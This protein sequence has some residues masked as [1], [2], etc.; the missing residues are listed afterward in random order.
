MSSKRS[1]SFNSNCCLET[2]ISTI[3]TSNA[4]LS[5]LLLLSTNGD[6][7]TSI[8]PCLGTLLSVALSGKESCLLK[9]V[10]CTS[11]RANR[12]IRT[13]AQAKTMP[14]GRFM[15]AHELQAAGE[16]TIKNRSHSK[17]GVQEK[18]TNC[19]SSIK[20]K[21]LFTYEGKSA[22]SSS[23]TSDQSMD[24]HFQAKHLVRKDLFVTLCRKNFRLP[25]A[26]PCPCATTEK[27]EKKYE[28]ISEKTLSTA[29]SSLSSSHIVAQ[30]RSQ[31]FC[32]KIN[33]RMASSHLRKNCKILKKK[34]YAASIRKLV[35]TSTIVGPTSIPVEIL[36]PSLCCWER[37]KRTSAAASALSI[38][39]ANCNA[40]A[41]PTHIFPALSNACTT[42]AGYQRD[43]ASPCKFSSQDS[44]HY[45]ATLNS[46]PLICNEILG[47]GESSSSK[48]FSIENIPPQFI[49]IGT[50]YINRLGVSNMSGEKSPTNC[51]QI[52]N[53]SLAINSSRTAPP[54]SVPK[55][56]SWRSP[57][58]PLRSY[59]EYCSVKISCNNA[60]RNEEGQKNLMLTKNEYQP[61]PEKNVSCLVDTNFTKI[62]KE[63]KIQRNSQVSKTTTKSSFPISVE[64]I[65]S[66]NLCDHFITSISQKKMDH[67]CSTINQETNLALSQCFFRSQEFHGEIS[68]RTSYITRPST[69]FQLQDHYQMRVLRSLES[70][71]AL[72]KQ[73]QES[74][75][76]SQKSATC[77]KGQCWR[78]F[79]ALMIVLSVST[80]GFACP[81]ACV[82][83]WKVGHKKGGKE[84]VECVNKGL[85]SLP[86][87]LNPETQVLDFTGN[88]LVIL[89]REKFKI[90][91]L[92]NLQRIYVSRCKL[93]QLDDA[94]FRGLSNLVELDLSNNE[95][96]MVPAA[97][98][99]HT[100]ALMRLLLSH[101][102]I[103]QIRDGAF[104]KLHFLTS[105]EMTG[106]AL[107]VLESRAFQGLDKLEWLKL[108][109]NQLTSVPETM[110]LPKMLHGV[111]L[112]N[113]PWHCDC[114]LQHLRS[115]LVK[116]NVPS[117]I[118]PK[119]S[120][121]QRLESQVIK[122]V[123]PEDFACPPEIRPTSLFLDV[124][125]GKNVSFACHVVAEPTADID[126]RFNGYPLQN[127]S[128]IYD[129]TTSFYIY[130]DREIKEETVSYLRIEMVT[131]AHGGI[132]Q[133]AAENTAGKMISNFTLR[134][135]VPPTVPVKKDFIEDNF[136]YIGLALAGLVLLVFIL[137]CILLSKCCRKKSRHLQNNIDA[138]TSTK[139]EKEKVQSAA[140]ISSM[141]KYIQ[142][143]TPTPKANGISNTGV[144]ISVIEASP[145]R[146]TP[147]GAPHP[148]P[149]IISD[150]SV[151]ER[152]KPKKKVSIM[153]VEEVDPNGVITT[154]KL[155]DIVEEYEDNFSVP[156]D[157]SVQN[158]NDFD[159]SQEGM[160]PYSNI[161]S[162]R[163]IANTNP[164]PLIDLPSTDVR[165]TTMTL[166]NRCFEAGPC[167]PDGY[168]M[169]KDDTW[170]EINSNRSV[171]ANN[172]K[173]NHPTP[174]YATLRR[175]AKSGGISRSHMHHDPKCNSE[176][177]PMHVSPSPYQNGSGR[178]TPNYSGI[179]EKYHCD[180][181]TP[182]TAS[183]S[184]TSCECCSDQKTCDT[185]ESSGRM[186]GDGCSFDNLLGPCAGGGSTA[187][188]CFNE[189]NDRI[190]DNSL[191]ENYAALNTNTDITTDPAF[192]E[193]PGPLPPEGW[194]DSDCTS[195]D[196]VKD[197]N[198]SP[199]DSMPLSPS[200][201][202]L[203]SPED[204]F[205]NVFST[206]SGTDT[207]S[208][209]PQ[210]TIKGNHDI[211]P[212][213]TQV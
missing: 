37:A 205:S 122:H 181:T 110:L 81:S 44:S 135:S 147:P 83:K 191:P 184:L 48:P 190:F 149:D 124:L 90:L 212:P 204:G 165:R 171:E 12:A 152:I 101:N 121:P 60:T 23:T 199:W 107:K 173:A 170:I 209:I 98:L 182:T 139:N 174:A 201:R 15:R 36:R 16:K 65:T 85:S 45:A 84:T 99:Q 167:R 163:I 79:F 196:L 21:A 177:Y 40:L 74:S 176:E 143:G 42:A 102:P 72:Y 185:S 100:A 35:F 178:F 206:P 87:G 68:R 64:K 18:E 105:L 140:P 4:G 71:S 26:R 43:T 19:T 86:T 134:V 192:F 186:S 200:T 156:F 32:S 189:T 10:I 130:E 155:N 112:H 54:S 51:M 187:N 96:N 2:R 50:T 77:L 69:K 94:A 148:N 129:D 179:V 24:S 153:G 164:Y 172:D 31:K 78:I 114:K 113:N 166:Q 197:N 28:I 9:P 92:I 125:E 211:L 63:S 146:S 144:P 123:L 157:Q 151:E 106:C 5:S 126:W 39:R 136:K 6:S 14:S 93:V 59:D 29:S 168:S 154:R 62:P 169:P 13:G 55:K 97:A 52:D 207:N 27:M 61:N 75:V 138:S 158:E 22:E 34:C 198:T 109:D 195:S 46:L 193:S 66:K 194:R 188:C 56:L 145:Y 8:S 91:G 38:Q 210:K 175:T 57:I 116:Y 115:W 73:R 3:P 89:S 58:A 213:A 67:K 20:G 120:T 150:S 111:D 183:T 33:E 41:L 47:S 80:P 103:T 25:E 104:S 133:C 88:A 127:S 30:K 128:F 117:S 162:C 11:V 76:E 159:P 119:C 160:N 161:S 70:S 142:M 131:V 1:S 180:G 208:C 137:C 7:F 95:L 108:D 141:P 132:F 17:A 118:E 82:C 53:V 203:Y 49:S 202:I